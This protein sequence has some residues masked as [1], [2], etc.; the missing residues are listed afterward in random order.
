VDEGIDTGN[1]IAQA[2]IEPTDKDSFVTYPY[3]L[4]EKAI[5]MVDKAIRDI[6]AGDLKTTAIEGQSEVWYHPGVVQY[7]VGRLRGVK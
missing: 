5:P 1:I 7:L 6:L 2:R 4:T 3:L